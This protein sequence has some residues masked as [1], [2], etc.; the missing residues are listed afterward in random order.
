MHTLTPFNILSGDKLLYVAPT[1]GEIR[2]GT[3]P[4]HSGEFHPFISVIT[5]DYAVLRTYNEQDGD[6]QQ[7]RY[8]RPT[9]IRI[10][11]EIVQLVEAPLD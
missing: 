8:Y 6:A 7:T 11:R 5:D 4:R 3:Q 9:C 10:R 2:M 1:G